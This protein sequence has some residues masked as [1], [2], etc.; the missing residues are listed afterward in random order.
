ML[1]ALILSLVF[2]ALS[3]LHVY[4]ALGNGSSLELT[5][6]QRNGKPVFQPGRGKTLLVALLLLGAATACSA[7]GGLFGLSSSSVS[8]AAVWLLVIA[9]AL[10]AVGDFRLVGVFKR[11]RDSRFARMDSWIY[12]PLCVVISAICLWL[13][14][15]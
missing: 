8:R 12:S 5:V 1:P 3:A 13:L 2:V 11:I 9:F 6:P 4:W 14:G 7:Q 15:S 10:R